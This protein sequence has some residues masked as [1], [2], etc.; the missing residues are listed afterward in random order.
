VGDGLTWF[1]AYPPK[2]CCLPDVTAVL[3]PLEHRPRY[4]I[5]QRTPLV[6]F[7][8]WLSPGAARWLVGMD[9]ELSFAL[10]HQ[11]GAQ[12]RQ[13]SLVP[14]RP[15]VRHTPTSA[16]KLRVE[17]L[18]WPMRT[19][20][21]GSVTLA[22]MQVAETLR[23]GQS[24]VV[25]WVVGPSAPR[26][27][28][29]NEFHLSEALG[30]KPPAQPDLPARRAWGRKTQ[31]PL[32]GVHGRVG[33]TASSTRTA[34]G[35]VRRLQQALSLAGSAHAR[36]RVSRPS[37]ATARQLVNVSGTRRRWSGIVNAP[38]LAMLIS[39]PIDGVSVPG[40]VG[41]SLARA[42]KKLLAATDGPP[43]GLRVLGR[44]LHPADAGQVVT[45]PAKSS[46]HHLHVVGP[47][48]AGKSTALAQLVLAD[49]KA[50]HGVLV[51]EPKGDLIEDVIARLPPERRDDIVLIEPGGDGPVVGFNPLAG[52]RKEAERRADE[53]L[54]LFKALFGTAIG[55]RSADVLL[56]ALITSARL[57]DGTLPDV[58]TLLTNPA[59]RRKALSKVNDPLVLAPFWAWYDTLSE[60]ER[61][62]VTA[63]IMNKLRVFTTRSAVR[64][65][66]GQPQPAFQPDDLLAKKRIVLVNLNRGLIGPQAAKL[67]GSLLLAQLWQAVLRRGKVP[68]RQRHPATVVVDEWQDY[69]GALDFGEVLAQ[70]RGLG[71]GFTLAHQHLGQLSPSLRAAVLANARSRLSYRPAPR[72][73]AA[74]ASALGGGVTSDDLDRLGAYQ[75]AVRVLVDGA[76]SQPFAVR[77]LP[78]TDATGDAEQLRRKSAT[79]FGVDGAAVDAEL[80]TRWQGGARTTDGPVGVVRRTAP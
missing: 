52:P 32:F 41:P 61:G 54:D 78:L 35:V 36:L 74:I 29:P 49:A 28:Q 66:L 5:A 57:P 18:A 30:L 68:V 10:P 42:P 22:L 77:T 33:A 60:A 15:P 64:Q 73:T 6:V 44:S 46:L 63:P 70:S 51:V 9:P 40:S 38:E 56:H 53:L 59:F 47:T 45:M 34:N 71:V 65:L 39:W 75:A 2:G 3:R 14:R 17:G 26:R 23:A 11:I 16:T 55:P 24:A 12:V 43:S 62:Q 58:P 21:A 4:G 31:E 72:D 13:L 67:L 37:A 20:M 19:E 69:T 79:H 8:L 48:G 27:V 50:G 1:E 7:E 80:I 76:P 25:Q